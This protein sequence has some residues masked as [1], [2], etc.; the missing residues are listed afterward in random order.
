[1]VQEA[2]QLLQLPFFPLQTCR[3]NSTLLLL[4][5]CLHLPLTAVLLEGE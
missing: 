5:L 3:V 4:L 1:M 2:Q